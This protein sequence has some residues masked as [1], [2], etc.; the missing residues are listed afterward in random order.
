MKEEIIY[1]MIDL[2]DGSKI[3]LC[4]GSKDKHR[5]SSF[6]IQ[7][8]EFV[9]E[10]L[11]L[12]KGQTFLD[13][14]CGAGEYS[15]YAAKLVGGAGTVYAIDGNEKGIE[16][17]ETD[18]FNQN[19]RNVFTIVANIFA[20]FEIED[21]SVDVCFIATV[22]HSP[23]AFEDSKE[24][25]KEIKRVLKPSGKLAILEM[26]KQ[27]MH[28]GPPMEMRISDDELIGI[29]KSHKFKNVQYSEFEYTYLAQFKY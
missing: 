29:M 22:L 1:E 13:L 5:P 2:P 28:F 27:P 23:Q 3:P 17:F 24:L 18:I 21:N 19:L 6:N 20:P 26:K 9:F 11:G 16:L 25:F 4:K 12:K 8:A 15:I 7:K 14:G 10:A